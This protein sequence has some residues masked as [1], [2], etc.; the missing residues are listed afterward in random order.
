MIALELTYLIA[1]SGQ[2]NIRLF[3][4]VAKGRACF[5]D[6]KWR[7]GLKVF[8]CLQL[9]NKNVVLEPFAA[10]FVHMCDINSKLTS[11]ENMDKK[12][13]NDDK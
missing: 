11:L 5:E 8:R 12:R 10:Q 4:V 3:L 2:V 13:V 7:I 1:Q 6:D 9:D